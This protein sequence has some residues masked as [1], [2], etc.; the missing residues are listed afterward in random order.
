MKHSRSLFLILILA[1]F[2]TACY[3]G[4]PE[5]VAATVSVLQPTVAAPTETVVPPAPTPTVSAAD[6][7]PEK[8][9]LVCQDRSSRGAKLYRTV[10]DDL[11][12]VQAGVAT[13]LEEVSGTVE[14]YSE[15]GMEWWVYGDCRMLVLYVGTAEVHSHQV[16]IFLSAD[17]D[18]R[19]SL[20]SLY[21]EPIKGAKK[22]IIT[23]TSGKLTI[24]AG[25]VSLGSK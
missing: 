13:Y 11:I 21:K 12:L 25:G 4:S 8:A 6:F 23:Q 20:R 10:G 24:E 5:R 14:Y 1:I 18:K 7:G 9:D 2:L 19:F 16:A 15:T 17:P 22:V 3:S